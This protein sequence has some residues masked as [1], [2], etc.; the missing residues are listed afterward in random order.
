MREVYHFPEKK[1][2]V[3]LC[4]FAVYPS[5]SVGGSHADCEVTASFISIPYRPMIPARG[6]F[7]TLGLSSPGRSL[8]EQPLLS[9][10]FTIHQVNDISPHI[11]MHGWVV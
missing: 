7:C 5:M 3:Y 8:L 2:H 11:Y 6:A 10:Q 9:G 4:Y 1:P